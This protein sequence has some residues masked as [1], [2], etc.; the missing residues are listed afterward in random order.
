MLGD[1]S[2]IL[3]KGVS[4][5]GKSTRVYLLLDYIEN[6]GMTLEP[7]FAKTL[8]GKTKEVGVY[9]KEFNIVFVGK[10]YDNGGIRRWQGYDSM[11]AR[12]CKSEGL[13]YF[14]ANEAILGHT[15]LLDGAGVTVTHRLRPTELVLRSGFGNILHVRY[16]YTE[17]QWDEYIERIKYR[18]GKPP[19]GD[20]MWKKR[21]TFQN[22]LL[23]AQEEVKGLT[24][25]G[26]TLETYDE[27][28][29][30]DVWDL[31][32]KILEFI[33]H[34]EACEDFLD[35]CL[36]SDYIQVNSFESFE[37]GKV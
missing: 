27:P 14:L 25:Y 21:K 18:S 24:E 10:F 11:T 31:G 4:G 19:R 23:K 29:D 3:I 30:I 5:S 1:P 16:D 2:I 12:L 37:D 32:V 35:F 9:S 17:D 20:Q 7:Y 33:G 6:L 13:S 22:D 8:D 28:Y 15:I 26:I 36:S 34:P